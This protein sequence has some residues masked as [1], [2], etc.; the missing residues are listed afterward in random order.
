MFHTGIQEYFVHGD[1]ELALLRAATEWKYDLYEFDKEKSFFH[2]WAAIE[3]F[4]WMLPELAL[5]DYEVMYYN[6]KPCIELGFCIKLP[7]GFYYRGYIDLVLQHKIDGS[8]LV[9][10]LKT[11]GARYSNP[12]K[13]QNSSQN[14]AYS[15]VL[16]TIMP[17]LQSFNVMYFEYLTSID[18]FIP[19]DFVIDNM[20]RATFIRD[21][22]MECDIMN[23]YDNNEDWPKHG[24]SCSGY[25]GSCQFINNCTMPTSML[26]GTHKIEDD[27][28]TIDK[29]A[30]YDIMISLEDIINSQLELLEDEI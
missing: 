1:K 4:I 17:G 8:I 29:K 16:D 18:K 14:I 5:A 24:E 30:P 12:A 11:S 28:I 9:V 7:N 20:E 22:L 6:G 23:F 3:K 27:P 15:V 21:L 26:L 25:G 10:D 19:H 2:C 13:Y